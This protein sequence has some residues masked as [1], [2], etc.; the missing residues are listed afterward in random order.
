MHISG[1]C[2]ILR[3]TFSFL[4]LHILKS[5]A[6]QALINNSTEFMNINTYYCYWS[7]S[8]PKVKLQNRARM[9]THHSE[10]HHV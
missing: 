6:G 8:T 4:I 7:G 2:D 1:T 9:S 10:M 3:A 5:C